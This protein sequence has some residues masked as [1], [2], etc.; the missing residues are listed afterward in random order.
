MGGEMQ[1]SR[2]MDYGVRAMVV[3]SVHEKEVLSKRT[4]ATEFKI[5]VNFLALILPKLVRSGLVES[6]PGPRGGYRLA[7]PSSRIS[8]Y[9][10]IT[11]VDGEVAFNRCL[12]A[13]RGCEQKSRCPVTVIWRKLQYDAMDY[14][15]G[16]TFERLARDYENLA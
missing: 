14:L 16:V 1:V 12:E 5:P 3:L 11:A 4:I 15:K 8:L 6:L 7:K 10:V 9:D 13:K 2:E